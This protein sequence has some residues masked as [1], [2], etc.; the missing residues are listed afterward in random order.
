[1]PCTGP[2]KEH[3]DR[4]GDE[5]AEAVLLLLKEK[6]HATRPTSPLPSFQKKFG[7]D[8]DVQVQKLH[9]VMRE[10]IWIDHCSSF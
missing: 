4:I 7:A 8:W 10:M 6:Y 1:M 3:A 5:V 2:N 9:E